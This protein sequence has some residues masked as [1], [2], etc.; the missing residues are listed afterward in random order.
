[1]PHAQLLSVLHTAHVIAVVSECSVPAAQLHCARTA[2]SHTAAAA[3]LQKCSARAA[4]SL[5]SQVLGHQCNLLPVA[6]GKVLEA[7]SE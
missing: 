2:T 5:S 6:A 3:P 7:A 4:A 1:M